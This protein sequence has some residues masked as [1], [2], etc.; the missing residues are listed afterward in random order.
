MWICEQLKMGCGKKVYYQHFVHHEL[1]KFLFCSQTIGLNVGMLMKRLKSM[2]QNEI[3]IM[4]EVN[5]S[6]KS[7]C[8]VKS[9][10][11]IFFFCTQLT[12]ILLLYIYK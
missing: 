9:K 1:D 7:V 5:N 6:T 12:P 10:G 2:S 3:K 8:N 11:P 4:E